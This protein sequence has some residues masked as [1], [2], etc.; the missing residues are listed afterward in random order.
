MVTIICCWGP[1]A[2]QIF[3]P[4]DHGSSLLLAANNHRLIASKVDHISII[5][6]YNFGLALEMY[7]QFC[8]IHVLE[9]SSFTYMY[10][11]IPSVHI[12]LGDM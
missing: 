10:L 11:Q 6:Y 8:S 7:W 4:N 3:W 2:P 9:H 12:K 5:I 1:F